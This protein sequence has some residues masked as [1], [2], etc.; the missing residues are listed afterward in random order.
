MYVLKVWKPSMMG[1]VN[2]MLVSG[3]IGTCI[4]RSSEFCSNQLM[5]LSSSNIIFS[6]D[7]THTHI[8]CV[9]SWEPR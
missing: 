1:T 8:Y 9:R 6:D 5:K 3:S 7:D 4:I 2:C